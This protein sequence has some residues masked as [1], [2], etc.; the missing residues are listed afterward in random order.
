MLEIASR[1]QRHG[2][3][4]VPAAP[5]VEVKLV[6]VA[7]DNTHEPFV[8]EGGGVVFATNSTAS[9]A[10]E[11]MSKPQPSY[12]HRFQERVGFPTA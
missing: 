7:L 5:G 10:L 11:I 4:A 8:E 3:G 1:N 2:H 6:G 12:G 9:I